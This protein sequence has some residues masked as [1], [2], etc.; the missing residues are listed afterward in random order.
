[1]DLSYIIVNT[2]NTIKKRTLT[3]ET[4]QGRK[5]STIHKNTHTTSHLCEYVSTETADSITLVKKRTKIKA[6][7]E[8]TMR[9]YKGLGP[10]L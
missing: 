3:A 5:C 8:K 9:M 10:D 7:K 4:K 2:S 6:L 1:M